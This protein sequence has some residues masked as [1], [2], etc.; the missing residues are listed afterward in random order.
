MNRSNMY[1]SLDDDDRS[2]NTDLSP[3]AYAFMIGGLVA[4]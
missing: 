3:V 4:N 1:E 2:L